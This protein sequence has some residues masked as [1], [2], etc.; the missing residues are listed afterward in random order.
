MSRNSRQASSAPPVA[1]GAPPFAPVGRAR[2]SEVALLAFEGAGASLAAP[3]ARRV[4]PFEPPI[5]ADLSATGPVCA[6][7]PDTHWTRTGESTRY[8]LSLHLL[9]TTTLR[10]S[11]TRSASARASLRTHTVAIT[12]WRVAV[13]MI[14]HG[15]FGV[16]DFKHATKQS[17]AWVCDVVRQVNAL[18]ISPSARNRDTLLALRRLLAVFGAFRGSCLAVQM[19]GWS[20]SFSWRR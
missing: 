17:M 9:M 19:C 14:Q 8:A 1:A 10:C 15:K 5:V 20:A 7:A 18:H 6:M 11:S 4:P 12:C 3:A 13:Y 16:R 2:R